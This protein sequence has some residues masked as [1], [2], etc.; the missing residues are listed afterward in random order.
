VPGWLDLAATRQPAFRLDPAFYNRVRAERSLRPSTAFV[1][2]PRS[3]SAFEVA[4]GQIFRVV[5]ESG[6]QTGTITF[7]NT[8]DKRENFS[9]ARTMAAEACFISPNTRLWADVPWFR[10]MATCLADT[11]VTLS[12]EGDCHHHTVGSHCSA[13]TIE[14]HFG[15]P[16]FGDCHQS[17]LAAVEPFG[18]TE[19]DIHDSIT[20]NQKTHLDPFHGRISITASDAMAGDYIEFYAEMDLLVAVAVCPF[21]NGAANPT[22][23]DA[24]AVH[25]LKVEIYDSSIAPRTYAAWT[26]WRPNWHGRWVPSK[27]GLGDN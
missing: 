17:L 5:Q 23:N 19:A 1:I 16:G 25:P 18:L 22:R 21:G 27:P 4:A 20:V 12:P 14:R 13:E 6:P 9:G 11:I 24:D 3:G 2:A 26:D 10:P 8:R 7:W 15:A